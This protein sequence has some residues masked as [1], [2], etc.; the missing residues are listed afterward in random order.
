MGEA[1]LQL[2]KRS[3]APLRDRVFRPEGSRCFGCTPTG[4]PALWVED[5]QGGGGGAM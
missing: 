2:R 1:G 4:R 3:W 5:S